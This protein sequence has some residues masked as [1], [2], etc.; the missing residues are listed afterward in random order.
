[1]NTAIV[2]GIVISKTGRVAAVAVVGAALATVC[3]GLIY[4]LDVGSSAGKWIG[5]QIIGGTGKHS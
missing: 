2:G 5:Y 1:M 4:S 3:C